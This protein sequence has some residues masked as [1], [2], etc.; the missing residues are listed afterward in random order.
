MRKQLLL[1]AVLMLSAA[2]FAAD[3]RLPMLKQGKTWNYVFHHF[4][5]GERGY[6]EYNWYV[7]YTLQGDT[8]IGG[9]QY[10]KMSRFDEK[11]LIRSYYG[12]F[13]E[14]EEGRVY[15]CRAGT[16]GE[17]LQIDFTLNNYPEQHTSLVP[18]KETIK[19]NGSLFTRYRY[20][21]TD[22]DGKNHWS[23]YAGVEGVGFKDCGLVGYIFEPKP[24]CICDYESFN[25]VFG[26]G[27]HFTNADFLAPKEILL[28]DDEKQ[29]VESNNDF[30]FRLFRQ[31]RK[32]TDNL[33][34]SPLSITYALGMLNNGAAGQTQEEINT[35]LG[36]KTAGAD[37]IN[38][39]CHKMLTEADELDEQTK[40]LISNT[41]FVNEGQ[42]YQLQ[43]PFI[44]K[45]NDY[46]DAQPEARDFADGKTRDVIN[47]WASDHTEGMIKEVLSQQEFNQWA[48][49]Y[50]LN[51][52]YF[53]GTWAS[54]F[55]KEQTTVEPF[56][57]AGITQE[58]TY[59]QMMHQ[60]E[61]FIH[62]DN[63]LYDAVSLPYGNG[64]YKMTVYLP[65]EG[66]LGDM[67]RQMNGSNWQIKGRTKDVD[68]KLPRFTTST[69]QG[70]NDI[71]SD[72][73]MPR[74]FNPYEAEFPYFCNYDVYI[75]MMKQTAK[76]KVDE[77]GT[78]A[79]AVTVIGEYTTSFK[80]PVT[81]HANRPF[82]YIISEQSTGII[83][84][85]GQY[86]YGSTSEDIQSGIHSV[87]SRQSATSNT[88]LLIY[89]LA[90]QRLSA[91]PAKGIYLQNGK[92]RLI[93]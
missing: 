24:N 65:R 87:D 75:G 46:Y 50:L 62:E 74:V 11:S 44:E 48:V 55:K 47:Q 49:S 93:K 69:N 23:D 39:F 79:A 9:R 26:D 59:C 45:A 29:L 20:R 52:I 91:P 76:I 67:L 56:Q 60:N 12:A 66:T 90:G 63:S 57:H 30:A 31:A 80:E 64:A 17:S 78:E 42:G 61:E 6:T 15:L 21:M 92:K 72:L 14:D 8:V 82:L 54:K 5:D 86:V 4:E 41:I 37:A 68:L 27:I 51:A 35:V 25:D 40:A 32:E 43:A 22:A 38:A 77:E 7:S 18:V 83:L 81:F 2:T 36:F 19:E 71:M 34:L 3:Q 73:G 10:M 84:F 85:M 33:I 16:T 88:S 28:T 53:K 58:M 13:R 70:L 89:N 1:F